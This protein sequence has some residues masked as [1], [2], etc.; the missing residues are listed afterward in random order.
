MEQRTIIFIGKS[1]SGKGTQARLLEDFFIKAGGSVCHFETGSAL[2]SLAEDTSYTGTLVKQTLGG[3]N[4]QPLFLAVWLW[5]NVFVRN[6]T[7]KEHIICDGFPRR[8]P[9]ADVLDTAMEFYGRGK[10]DVVHC[11]LTDEQVFERLLKRGRNDDTKEGIQ[12]RLE[13]FENEVMPVVEYFKGHERYIVHEIDAGREECP[14]F[15]DIKTA[16][17]V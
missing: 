3:G 13:W 15:E 16:L 7:G 14:V 6:L 11:T 12:R 5:G 2:R 17:G 4:M 9:E 10:V 1:G 8:K